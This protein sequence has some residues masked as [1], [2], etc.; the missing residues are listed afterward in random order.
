MTTKEELADRYGRTPRPLRRH[1][2]WITVATVAALSIVG[3]SWLT[4]SNAIDDVGFNETGYE[5]VDARTVRVSFQVTPPA[6]T[7]FACA[8]QALDED[9]GIVGWRVIE[10]PASA[11]ITRALVETIRTV[12]QPTTGTVQSCWA[13]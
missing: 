7:T 11:Q 10:Y 6:E 8:V 1:V 2:F 13:T 4:I 9:F 5:L 12:A 3:L